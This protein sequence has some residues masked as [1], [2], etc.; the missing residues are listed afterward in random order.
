MSTYFALI[1]SGILENQNI[2]DG[3]KI[4]YSLILGLSNRYGYC[5][6]TNSYLTEQRKKSESAIRSHLQELKLYGAITV[7]YNDR[8]DRRIRPVIIPTQQEKAVKTSKNK[9]YNPDW[10]EIDNAL[11]TVWKA[12]K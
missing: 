10:N 3:A 7:E 2:S 4:T 1:P 9:Q 5:F 11:D 8:N 6:A 12:M